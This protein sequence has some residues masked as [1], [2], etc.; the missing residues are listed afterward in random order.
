MPDLYQTVTDNIIAAMEHAGEWKMPWHGGITMPRNVSGRHY[1][2][3][4]IFSLWLAA[5]AKDYGEGIWA[6]Y[7]QWAELG[8]QVR[9]GEKSTTVMFWKSYSKTDDEGTEHA[10][11]AARAFS[12]FNVAQVD[13]YAPPAAEVHD[14]IDAAESFISSVP[15]TV[16]RG[17]RAC[18]IP[19]KDYIEIPSF[20]KFHNP[21]AYYSTLSHELAHWT[22]HKSRLD[23]ELNTSRFDNEAYAFEELI[24]ELSAAFL[25]AQLGVE[26]TPRPDHA[27]YLKSWLKVLNNDKRAI[28]TAASKAQAATDYLLAFQIAQQEAAR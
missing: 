20:D 9:K 8:A 27:S 1:R 13:G 11:S 25:C 28:F 22:G 12:V 26:N 2:G 4:N 6:T 21:E 10:R 16:K 18:Y 7:K 19:S 5:D 3:I 23:R 15:A 17:D 24:A 14:R